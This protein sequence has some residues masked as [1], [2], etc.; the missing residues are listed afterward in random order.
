RSRIG[1]CGIGDVPLGH[2]RADLADVLR[3]RALIETRL[4][5]RAVEQPHTG[6]N[7]EPVPHADFV[8]IVLRE[9][10]DVV[11]NA[12]FR[13]TDVVQVGNNKPASVRQA[14]IRGGRYRERT[15]VRGG[16][17]AV[18]DD[19][20]VAVPTAE[21]GEVHRDARHDLTLHAGCEL[22]VVDA[23]AP[24][25]Q[26]VRIEIRFGHGRP[27]VS[28]RYRATLAVDVEIKQVA[29]RY[30]IAVRVSPRTRR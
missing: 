22:P 28:I 26:D 8:P 29:I 14:G 3:Q 4:Q 11:G 6:A 13:L 23:L 7:G 15:E 5:E 27:E 24:A 2:L 20:E 1:T 30:V 25:V 19:V 16:H 9:G 21:I 12:E 17:G 18:V 10:R